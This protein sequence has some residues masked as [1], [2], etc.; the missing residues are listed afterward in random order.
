MTPETA[1]T[2]L[3]NATARGQFTRQEHNEINTAL[4]V[5]QAIIKPVQ[6]Q[7]ETPCEQP[8]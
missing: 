6:P 4:A 7:T 2:V 1:L 3:V 8:S 5:I